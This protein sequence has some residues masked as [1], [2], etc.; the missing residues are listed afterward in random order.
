MTD[1]K[2]AWYQ[3]MLAKYGSEEAVLAEMRRRAAKGGK[4]GRT[5]G[6]YGKPDLAR[7][8]A[9]RSNKKKSNEK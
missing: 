8:M 6:F 5:G 7:A 1:T 9:I 4:N 3:T 2:S